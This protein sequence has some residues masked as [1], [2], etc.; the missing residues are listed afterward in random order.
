MN[1]FDSH[2]GVATP[3]S[4]RGNIQFLM[5]QLEVLRAQVNAPIRIVSGYRSPAHNASVGGKGQSRHM[6]G[7]A[8][9]IQITGMTPTEVHAT[10][11]RLITAGQ[12]QQ[13]GLG[14]YRTF[15]HYDTRGHKAR[16]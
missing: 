2:D 1:E 15:V 13:G 12:M 10:I 6:C 7:Q 9:D 4:V 5:D 14:L 16:W 11:E 8:A 3:V